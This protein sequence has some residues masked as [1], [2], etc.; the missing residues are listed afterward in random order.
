MKPRFAPLLWLCLVAI[1]TVDAACAYRA[2]EIS[3]R[4]GWGLPDVAPMTT[5]VET[6]VRS[7]SMSVEEARSLAAQIA[8]A[9]DFGWQRSQ[10]DAPY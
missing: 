8:K 9:R 5:S 2:G 4:E 10:P 3:V 6:P 7:T 1:V